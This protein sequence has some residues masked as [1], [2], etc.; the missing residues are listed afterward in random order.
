M[1]VC[2]EDEK[3]RQDLEKVEQLESKVTKELK[4]LQTKI[5]QMGTDLAT[6][7]DTE[8][9]RTEAEQLKQVR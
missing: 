4:E 6:Y 9:Q 1:C 8:T 7:S 2:A 5:D 3:L